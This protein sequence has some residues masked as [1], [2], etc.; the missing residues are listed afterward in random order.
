MKSTRLKKQAHAA[1]T[2]GIRLRRLLPAKAFLC[3]RCDF[4]RAAIWH[5]DKGYAR[6]HW[7]SIIPLCRTCH[8]F[9]HR[10]VQR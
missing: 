6:Q 10:R 9:V 7:F 1:V 8:G 3:V 4:T 2:R 5:H